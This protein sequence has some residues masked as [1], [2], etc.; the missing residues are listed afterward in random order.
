MTKKKIL[1]SQ[2]I[3]GIGKSLEVGLQLQTDFPELADDYRNGISAPR[4]VAKY[5]LDSRY[6][7]SK[8]SAKEAVYRA[9]KG[10]SG[11]FGFEYSGLLDEKEIAILGLEH[12][13][14][15]GHR[16]GLVLKEKGL[17]LFSLTDEQWREVHSKGGRVSGPGNLAT[18]TLEE[19]SKNGKKS[20]ELRRGVHGQTH[21]EHVQ[22]GKKA[23]LASAV[24]R[25]FTPW[26]SEETEFLKA[27]LQDPEYIITQGFF[28]GK[29]DNRLIAGRL[30]ALYH[31]GEQVRN[32]SSVSS[33]IKN[34][35]TERIR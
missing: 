24:S 17:G 2:Q 3:K 21:E 9:L 5:R 14:E 13:K 23:G 16:N 32:G 15:N 18:I 6:G 31:N 7:I 26:G 33:K 10:V 4:I 20:H 22:S 34:Y 19:R 30:N 8:L 35:F 1:T 11:H 28:K 27:A 25:G 29:R 12:I